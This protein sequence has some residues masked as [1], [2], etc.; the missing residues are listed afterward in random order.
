MLGNEA[1]HQGKGFA[2]RFRF[3][4]ID[5]VES[6]R[7]LDQM[8]VGIGEPGRNG[9][10]RGVNHA[11]VTSAQRAELGTPP[12]RQHAPTPYRDRI[13]PGNAHPARPYRAVLHQEIRHR[14]HRAPLS[15][16]FSSTPTPSTSTSTESPTVTGPTPAG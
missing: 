15:T 1:A 5:L 11:R 3:A 6:P 9:S 10:A 4:E 14:P 7:P 16:R 2:T 12:N 13:D 8:H